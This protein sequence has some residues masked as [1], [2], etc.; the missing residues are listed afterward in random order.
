MAILPFFYN[1]SPDLRNLKLER[2]SMDDQ[3]IKDIAA[4]IMQKVKTDGDKALFSYAKQFDNS[5]LTNLYVSEE[6]FINAEKNV[7]EE[8]KKAIRHAKENIYKFHLSQMPKAEEVE[9]Q[10][11]ILCRRKIVPIEKVGLYV[12]GGTAP[13]FST[14]LMLA[15]PAIIASCADIT[16]ATPAKNG[17]VNDITLFTAKECGI[18]KVIKVGGAQAIAAFTYGTETVNKVDKIFGP[19]NRFVASAKEIASR[20]ISIDMVAGPSEV[21]VIADK[22]TNPYY[23]AADLLSQ[24]EHGMDSQVVLLIKGTEME[25]KAMYDDVIEKI[26]YYTSILGRKEFMYSSLESSVC[27]A[28]DNYND[29]I[30]TTNYYAP[31]HLIINTDNAD[32]IAEKIINA[33]SIFVGEFTPESVGD[34][35]SGTNHT[36]P[37]L[38]F[39]K[40]TGG[41]SLDSFLKKI[42]IQ[43]LT[44]EGLENL[45]DTVITMAEAEELTAHA[46]AVKV[47]CEK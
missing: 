13:L 25:S 5:D 40:S 31:E 16:I 22:N 26:D 17:A 30:D 34:Y 20:T 23:I 46:Q 21:L 3:Q 45:K 36:L 15:V 7:S 12:P 47:R 38:G 19:G 41:V 6:E 43:K 28:F 14:V 42:T 35:A 44:R 32:E 39:A 1:P 2:P 11:G 8:L 29:I 27:F 9:T 4:S 24:A 37:T 18:K 33:G 10:K